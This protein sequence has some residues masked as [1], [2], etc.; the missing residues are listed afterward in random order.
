MKAFDFKPGE[1]RHRVVTLIGTTQ[2]AWRQRYAEVNRELTLTGYLV[3]SVG[4]FRDD[5]KDIEIHRH[6]LESIHF[7]KIDMADVVVLID[8]KAV[9]T[10]TAIEMAYARR[11]GK[12]FVVFH[13]TK[14][15]IS[16]IESAT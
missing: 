7:Q 3:V 2:P 9:S 6:T 13:N 15:A 12:P 5:L 1:A 11:I 4:V 8:E 16:E 14:Q 10:N